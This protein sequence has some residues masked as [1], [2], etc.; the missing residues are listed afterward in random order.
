LSTRNDLG[1]NEDPILTDGLSE[2]SEIPSFKELTPDS[3]GDASNLDSSSSSWSSSEDWMSEAESDNDEM[4]SLAGIGG[5]ERQDGQ[6]MMTQ[7]MK[8]IFLMGMKVMMR[9]RKRQIVSGVG[10]TMIYAK[11]VACTNGF[12]LKSRACMPLDIRH[13]ENDYHEAHHLST[14][15]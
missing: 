9:E 8:W 11:G 13:Q 7:R 3:D 10:W 1:I 12:G 2:L 5:S 14:M 6:Q 15:F 4:C